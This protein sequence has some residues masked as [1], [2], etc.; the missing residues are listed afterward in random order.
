MAFVLTSGNLY[1]S[2]LLKTLG[3]IEHGFGTN[4]ASPIPQGEAAA[5]LMQVH[6]A[7]VLPVCNPDERQQEGDGILTSTPNL[8]ISIRTADCLPI[9]IG[10]RHLKAVA[11]VHAGWKGTVQQIA[12]KAV[13]CLVEEFG[14]RPENL[15]AA[16][17]PG[18]SDCCYE[19]GH[20]VAIQFDTAFLKPGEAGRSYLNLK[21]ANVS[22]LLAAGLSPNHIDVA[23]ECSV[24]TPGFHSFRRDK[25]E[26]RMLSAIRIKIGAD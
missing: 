25:T 4:S 24:S 6:S 13:A 17:G 18:I 26:G 12:R 15:F 20:E 5:S 9:L 23:E 19:V 21:Q 22:Q 10:D 8:W 3:W 11:A 16:I 1:L 2:P 14:S 7:L